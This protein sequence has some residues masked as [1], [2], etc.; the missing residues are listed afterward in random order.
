[1]GASP[2]VRNTW[3]QSSK[4]AGRSPRSRPGTRLLGVQEDAGLSHGLLGLLHCLPPSMSDPKSW[5]QP[6]KG[7]G[8]LIQGLLERMEGLE[9]GSWGMLDA[10]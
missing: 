9:V 6:V 8:S 5:K 4:K 1:M 10:W 7:L 2:G 3:Q